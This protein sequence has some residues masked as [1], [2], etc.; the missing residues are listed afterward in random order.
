MECDHKDGTYNTKTNESLE[1]QRM[2]DFQ[3]LSKAVNDAKR[4]HCKECRNNHCVKRYDAKR[5]GYLVSDV[6][7][8]DQPFCQGCYW[9][10]PQEFNRIVSQAFV[11]VA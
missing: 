8:K 4:Q 6:H 5:L 2:E 11:P 10:D 7:I 9:N 3:S 1:T